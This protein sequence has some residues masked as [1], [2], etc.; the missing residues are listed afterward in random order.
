MTATGDQM[1]APES[2]PGALDVLRIRPFAFLWLGQL[3]SFLGD[4]SQSIGIGVFVYLMT[5]SNLALGAVV[6]LQALPAML[7]GPLG[8]VIVDRTDKK[9]LMVTCDVVRMVLV[10]SLALFPSVPYAYT[11]S[12]L[13]S[14]LGVIF[15]TAR[16]ATIPLV[17][18]SQL[19]MAANSFVA[20]STSMI[21]IIGPA[22]G[23][24]LV[25][26]SGPALAFGANA[27]SYAFSAALILAAALPTAP[28]D[29]KERPSFLAAL[30]QGIGGITGNPPLRRLTGLFLLAMVAV[31]GAQVLFP[32]Y[33]FGTLKGGSTALGF[34]QSSQ[35]VGALVG[36]V[37][38][39][40]M[41]QRLPYTWS[42]SAGL[43]GLGA[44]IS[45]LGWFP[46][47]PAACAGMFVVGTA[48][49]AVNIGANTAVMTLIPPGLLGRVGG[50][51]EA[52][53]TS[54]SLLSML[55]AGLLAD[56]LGV[57]PMMK[58]VGLALVLSAV[59]GLWRLREKE[60]A[61]SSGGGVAPTKAA[62]GDT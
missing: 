19:V 12:F 20:L 34:I 17:V 26:L 27:A 44:G 23:G 11:V 15:N 42:I 46:S 30:R 49:T 53:I 45:V 2:K 56:R 62:A 43:A 5:G 38:V 29:G 59:Y 50:T 47:L 16:T 40:A 1:S 24:G 7:F 13:V 61:P 51:L 35:G 33:V 39:A 52:L 58:A 14:S 36:A 18:G 8:G 22:V 41:A 37:V 4:M 21:R 9:R 25:A 32:G 3:V 6:A 10:G 60:T 54:V 31:G 55:A 48:L 57:V 28:A